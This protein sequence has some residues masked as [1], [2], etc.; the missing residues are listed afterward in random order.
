MQNTI[1]SFLLAP[2]LVNSLTYMKKQL[3]TASL[4]TILIW[5]FSKPKCQKKF[6]SYMLP[7]VYMICSTLGTLY[8]HSLHKDEHML[9][10]KQSNKYSDPSSNKNNLVHSKLCYN[11]LPMG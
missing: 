4:L 8:F 9:M 6:Q 3:K 10:H 5:Y 1:S 2:Y 7:C 11:T